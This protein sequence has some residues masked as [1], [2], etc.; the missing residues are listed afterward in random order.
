MQMRLLFVL[1][2]LFCADRLATAKIIFKANFETGDLSEWSQ[3]GTR[4]QNATPG[5]VEVVTDIVQEQVR[6]KIHHS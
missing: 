1:V 2:L 3:T 6:R 5:N 4:S